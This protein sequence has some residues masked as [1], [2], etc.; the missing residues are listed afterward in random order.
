MLIS[1][2]IQRGTVVVPKSATAKRI[3]S[4]FQ[5]KT[6][7]SWLILNYDL[8]LSSLTSE[9]SFPSPWWCLWCNPVAGT[10]STYELPSQVRSWYIRR[11]W[12]G[13]RKAKCSRMGR[14]SEEASG[15]LE[16]CDMFCGID[17]QKYCSSPVILEIHTQETTVSSK[18][19]SPSSENSH[20]VNCIGS[21]SIWKR[22]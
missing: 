6:L 9:Q 12:R 20:L 18:L 16:E 1:W 21:Q 10:P 13:K 15:K 3:D 14:K 8:K 17:E 4:N 11:S 7:Y 22:Y 19:C 2:S 5:G